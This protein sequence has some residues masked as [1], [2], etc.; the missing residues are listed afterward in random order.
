MLHTAQELHGLQVKLSWLE[1]LGR[2]EEALQAYEQEHSRSR[3]QERR[4]LH[5]GEAR[6]GRLPVYSLPHFS[7]HA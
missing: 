1:K 7:F 4:S 2:W 5:M 6:A 3:R